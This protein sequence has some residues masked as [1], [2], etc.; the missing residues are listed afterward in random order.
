M[1][2]PPHPAA[3]GRARAFVKGCCQS[4]GVGE[5]EIDVVVLLTSETVTNALMHG[6]SE[7]RLAVT[8]P[9]G[10]VFV[11]VADDN[12]R[13]PA[14]VA[15]DDAALDGRGLTILNTLASQW[16]VRDEALGK[17]VW[18]HVTALWPSA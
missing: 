2:L 7:A 5:E 17:T 4:V 16:G 11:E 3:V 1:V 10:S 15:N 14:A 8:F 18:F 9:A 6:R 12:S 13:H